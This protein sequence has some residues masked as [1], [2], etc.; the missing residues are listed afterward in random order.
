MF[1]NFWCAQTYDGNLSDRSPSSGAS[2]WGYS[3]RFEKT[4]FGGIHCRQSMYQHRENLWCVE[5]LYFRCAGYVCPQ[6]P[7]Q[8]LK[9]K[10]NAVVIFFQICLVNLRKV[11]RPAVVCFKWRG[12]LRT[13][14]ACLSSKGQSS[15]R[16]CWRCVTSQKSALEGGLQR[17]VTLYI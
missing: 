2:S 13:V 14:V 11:A 12:C 8:L 3:H 15:P 10:E 7:A 17:L 5:V 16:S 4:C 9:F 6:H 1:S